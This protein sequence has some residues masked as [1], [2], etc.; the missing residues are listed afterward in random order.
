MKARTCILWKLN[1]EVEGKL[2]EFWSIDHDMLYPGAHMQLLTKLGSM[3]L[4]LI[5]ALSQHLLEGFT[6]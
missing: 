4:M 5:T 6:R 2:H 1:V 3:P